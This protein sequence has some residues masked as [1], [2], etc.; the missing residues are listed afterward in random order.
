[1]T[2]P[3]PDS[4]HALLTS[5][6]SEDRDRAW[7]RF[8][9]EHSPLLLRVARGVNRDHDGVMDQYAYVLEA[10][11]RENCQRLGAWRPEGHGRFET[12]LVVVTRRLCFDFHRQRYGR[13]QRDTAEAGARHAERR[14]LTDLVSNELGLAAIASPAEH[15]PDM[16]LRVGDLRAA[17]RSAIERLDT[18]DRVLLRLRFEDGLSVPEIARLRGERS[19][20]V[21]YRR[22]DRLLVELRRSLKAAGIVDSSA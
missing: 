6:T 21:L 7:T 16:Q 4:L 8:L 10:L 5:S 3:V 20:F 11:R 19:P 13:Q 17:L 1:M 2:H 14:N 15:S 18:T 22:I 12:W 9:E